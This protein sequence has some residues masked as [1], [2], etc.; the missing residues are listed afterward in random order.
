MYL[1]LNLIS[2][3]KRISLWVSFLWLAYILANN[4]YLQETFRIWSFGSTQ[5]TNIVMDLVPYFDRSIYSWFWLHQLI[6][7]EI[8]S[9]ILFWSLK[10]RPVVQKL[11]FSVTV[12]CTSYVKNWISRAT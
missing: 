9:E 8:L 10:I 12:Q 2:F 6:A 4:R 11:S 7:G 3:I 5:Y 1:D